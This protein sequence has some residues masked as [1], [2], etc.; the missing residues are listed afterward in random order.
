MGWVMIL[1]KTLPVIFP[2][3]L[4]N[5]ELPSLGHQGGFQGLGGLRDLPMTP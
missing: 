5:E 3:T 1:L 4:Q 2:S